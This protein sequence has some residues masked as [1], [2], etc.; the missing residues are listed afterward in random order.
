MFDHHRTFLR[1]SLAALALALLGACSESN[2]SV[3][4]TPDAPAAT[5]LVL[6]V[7]SPM[8]LTGLD[9]QTLLV[10][11]TRSNAL[12]LVD[13]ASLAVE[14]SIRLAGRP[15]GVAQFN[16]R[17]F[18]G[19]RTTGRVD[20]LELDGTVLFHLGDPG[21]FP[22]VNDLA[23]DERSGT[24]YVL[25]TS[26]AV[27]KA[28]RTSDGAATGVTLSAPP[29]LRP[30]ALAVDPSDG[31]VLV[32]DYGP[33]PQVLAFSDSGAPL[34]AD[35]ILGS[36]VGFSMP[37]GLYVD[38]NHNVY[39]TEARIGEVLVIDPAKVLVKSLGNRGITEGELLYPLDVFVDPVRRDVYVTDNQNRRISAFLGGGVSP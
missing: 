22:Q 5:P 12:H 37:Q 31:R 1:W 13:A 29:L 39:L 16:G 18:V 2:T 32:S 14:R 9:A 30:T 6:P 27:V 34:T 35:T 19:N 21:E 36:A 4:T 8:R 7:S 20:V 23:I 33:V 24:V 38:E 3:A 26:T 11:D 15:S 28:Y 17:I 25:D 10:S